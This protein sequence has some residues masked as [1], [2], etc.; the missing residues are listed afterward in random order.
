MKRISLLILAAALMLGAMAFSIPLREAERNH[1][2]GYY[3]NAIVQ[4]QIALGKKPTKQEK[5]YI[6]FQMG[7]C[8]RV[9]A[10]WKDALKFYNQA[11]RADF[12]NDIVY[13]RRGDA[14]RY[15][16]DYANARLDY[17]EYQKRVPSDPAGVIGERS[18]DSAASWM[19]DKT[20]WKI[21]NETELNSRENDFSPSW[22]D[23]KR[24]ALFVTSKRPGQTGTKID[25]ISGGLYADVFESRQSRTGQWSVPS[26]V[27]GINTDVF[28][29][30][31]P[32]I[33]RNGNKMYYTRCGQQKKTIVTCK[34]Y[35]AD[36]SGNGWNNVQVV[37]FGLDA[38]TL[39]SFNFR[40][41]AISANGEVMVFTS[42]LPGSRGSDLWMSVY[43]TKSRSWGKPTQLGSEINTPG[44]E[45][46]PYI[47][48][49]G[50]LYFASDGHA[51]MGGLDM[52]SAAKVSA[53]EWKWN[54]VKNLK[55]PLN[56]SADDFGII[57]TADKKSGY[58]SS[59]RAGT[60]GGDDIW[61]FMVDPLLCP[62]RISGT[63]T[64]RKN[65]IPV[66]DAL[67]NV[68][69]TDG[70]KFSIATDASGNYAFKAKDN[71]SYTITVEGKPGHTAKASS[72]FNLP[73]NEKRIV[74]APSACPCEEHV[75]IEIFP[76][77]PIEIKFPAV[78]YEY[79]SDKLTAASK[80]SLDYLY[81]LLT[82]NPT[83]VIELG[84]H[85]DCRGSANY[86]RDLAQR[87]AQACVNYLVT[88]KKIP[89][90]RI[91]AKGY[92][93]DQPL[94]IGKDTALTES[95]ISRQPKDKQEYLHSLNRRTVFRVLNYNYTPSGAQKKEPAQ[96]PVIR[97][98][99]FDA[100]DST[101]VGGEEII[102]NEED[103]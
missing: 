98:G 67:V 87:R 14:Y 44:R 92:G 6:Y 71:V 83:M 102:E 37:D 62:M 22:A 101:W 31:S 49:D 77:D 2:N 88:E 45:A 9:L 90:E 79:N 70:S 35:C 99:Y 93:E 41:P 28:N 38:A 63:V 72:Y 68:S 74:A 20:W 64:D 13:L 29:E 39:D 82:D 19:Q 86:N 17:L 8:S 100:S 81:R 69:G 11:I 75:D 58:F 30:G 94:R 53:N 24:K 89:R 23:K 84:S 65:K 40:H 51:G 57:F 4:Y 56:S 95:Y 1:Q 66:E 47:H 97:K 46:F 3:H 25:P 52:F 76:V 61:S 27:T 12:V 78:L 91:L 10:L 7:E 80:D 60:K 32:V 55:F 26:S 21:T 50:S 33:T 54:A 85:T 16:G 34:I 73:E 43:N 18:C 42:D 15:L 103:K 96:V 48:D 59:S 36:K 5:G